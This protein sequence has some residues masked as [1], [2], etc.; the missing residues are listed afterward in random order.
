M[1]TV[2][3]KVVK[4]QN[5][6]ITM[7]EKREREAGGKDDFMARCGGWGGSEILLVKKNVMAKFQGQLWQDKFKVRNG[8]R[9][10]T[11]ALE[12][13]QEQQENIHCLKIFLAK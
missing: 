6:L 4:T 1:V 2:E 8:L 11:Q 10:I 5:V 12:H 9:L 3:K 13:C 7:H